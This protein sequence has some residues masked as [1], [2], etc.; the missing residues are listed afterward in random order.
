GVVAAAPS[1][2]GKPSKWDVHHLW[3]TTHGLLWAPGFTRGELYAG[4]R[5]NEAA[6]EAH[7]YHLDEVYGPRCAAHAHPDLSAIGPATW[8]ECPSCDSAP[9]QRDDALA[10]SLL[11]GGIRFWDSEVASVDMLRKT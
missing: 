10:T 1:R 4:I 8:P 2:I 5:L 6:S 7:W 11:K 9:P 3:H